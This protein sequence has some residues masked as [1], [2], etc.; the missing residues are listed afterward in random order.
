[1]KMAAWGRILFGLSAVGFGIIALKW[2]DSDTWQQMYAILS[3]PL[4]G[5]VGVALMTALIG[6]GIAILFPPTVRPGAILLGVV[7]ASFSLACIAVIAGAP[8]VFGQYDAFFEQLCLLCGAVAVYAATEADAA[9]SA[10]IGR[11][12]RVG[13]G[14]STISF[15]ATQ[16]YYLRETAEL[17]PKWIPLGQMFWAIATTVAFG[18]AAIA[19]LANRQARLAIR[20]MALMMALFGVLVWVP[21][22]VAHPEGHNNW[23][24]GILTFLLAGAAGVVGELRAW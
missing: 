23:S 20:L 4:G 13:L 17:V 21:I 15:T 7:F 5:V 2:H 10:W 19:I 9:R 11:M 3:W 1:M 12:A 24:E 6:G 22:L 8:K 16:I 14:L 18:L